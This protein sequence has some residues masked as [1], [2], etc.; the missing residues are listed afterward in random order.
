MKVFF[1]QF[2][3]PLADW[4][5]DFLPQ[6]RKWFLLQTQCPFELTD[7]PV[8]AELIVF[9]EGNYFKTQRYLTIL[10]SNSLLRDYPEK[11]FTINYDDE[12]AGFLPGLYTS[13]PRAKYDPSRHRAWCYVFRPSADLVARRNERTA[14]PSLLFSFRGSPT[15]HSI[16]RC[17]LTMDFK[18]ALP[19]RL[20]PIDRWFNHT[21]DERLSYIDE[22]LESY[23]A[24]C[25]RGIAPTSIRLF[26]VMALGRCPVIISDDW[27]PIEGIDWAS[28]SIQIPESDLHLLPERLE[29]RMDDAKSL[30]AS[31]LRVWE[32][33]FSPSKVIEQS[34][35][36]ILDV[37]N[38]RLAGYDERVFQ[39]QWKSRKFFHLNGWAVEQRLLRRL[40]RLA[41]TFRRQEIET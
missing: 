39:R 8:E 15:S 10:Y 29:S 33:F 34:L 35:K 1:T 30:G 20:T 23:F 17:L 32:K 14:A 16:R 19:F 13:L 37:A 22:I 36:R 21:P 40:H 41:A 4:E 11:C 5:H 6:V 25:P 18:T 28:C 27:V 31:A 9:L 3:G 7:S 12:A 38:S 24:L 26:E 2:S